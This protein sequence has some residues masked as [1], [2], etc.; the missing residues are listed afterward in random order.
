M[1]ELFDIEVKHT[2]PKMPW[3]NPYAERF[4]QSLKNELISR[5]EMQE[6]TK[7]RSRCIQFR[8]YY[9]NLRPH[10]GIGGKRPSKELE[11]VVPIKHSEK[12]R[13]AKKSELDG[14]VARFKLVA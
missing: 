9:N 8:E 6:V 10:Q 1:K 2:P 12:I 4:H 14:L 3:F 5:T 11:I 13:F 7:V